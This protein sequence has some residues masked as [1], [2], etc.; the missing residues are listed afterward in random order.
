MIYITGLI[1]AVTLRVTVHYIKL[2]PGLSG[3]G[4]DLIVNGTLWRDGWKARL[5]RQR[6]ECVDREKVICILA[7]FGFGGMT[8]K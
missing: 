8:Y 5:V 2:K 7:I 6:D 1:T 4:S 3:L